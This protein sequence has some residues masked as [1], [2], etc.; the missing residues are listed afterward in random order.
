MMVLEVQGMHGEELRYKEMMALKKFELYIQ[1][2]KP[3]HQDLEISII[4]HFSQLQQLKKK[5]NQ[6]TMYSHH[7]ILIL[8]TILTITKAL[9]LLPRQYSPYG[10]PYDTGDPYDDDDNGDISPTWLPD[11]Y[12]GGG[13]D[14][15]SSTPSNDDSSPNSDSGYTPTDLPSDSYPTAVVDPSDTYSSDDGDYLPASSTVSPEL[16]EETGSVVPTSSIEGGKTSA[17]ATSTS[18]APTNMN[19]KSNTNA[20]GNGASAKSMSGWRFVVPAAAAAAVV[21]CYWLG[22]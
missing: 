14:D 16:A 7:I 17:V 20:V 1:T 15:S 9:H 3:L 13:G 21:P 4:A 12:I 19:S 18:T 8:L 2:G 11:D 22:L 5:K 6:S 10:A